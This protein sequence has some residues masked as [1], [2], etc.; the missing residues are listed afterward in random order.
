MLF[1]IFEMFFVNPAKAEIYIIEINFKMDSEL[2][3]E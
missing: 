2:N 1:I 3:A